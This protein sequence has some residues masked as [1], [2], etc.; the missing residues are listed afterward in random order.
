MLTEDPQQQRRYIRLKRLIGKPE[1]PVQTACRAKSHRGR[2]LRDRGRPGYPPVRP[3][4][5]E[6]ARA[7]APRSGFALVAAVHSCSIRATKR[8]LA[9]ALDSD[10][11]G[12]ISA[13]ERDITYTS[14]ALRNG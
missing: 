2:I 8:D 14:A 7:L 5:P 1:V 12:T 10:T 6:I 3:G 13:V 9:A 11:S 4:Q